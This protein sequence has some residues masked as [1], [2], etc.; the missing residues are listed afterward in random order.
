[1]KKRAGLNA[2]WKERFRLKPLQEPNE[3]FLQA[4]SSNLITDSFIGESG[5]LKLGDIALG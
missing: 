4:F 1:M 3:F 5:I 2:E